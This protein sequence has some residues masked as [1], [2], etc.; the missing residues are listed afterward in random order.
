MVH[1]GSPIQPKYRAYYDP[2]R[3]EA[4]VCE[5]I[6]LTALRVLMP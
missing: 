4:A 6:L 5:E 3:N 1:C 2:K